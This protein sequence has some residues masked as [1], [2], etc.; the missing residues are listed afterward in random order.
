M[1]KPDHWHRRLLRVR[2]KRPRG[3]TA[4]QRDQIAP[5][6]V[7]HGLPPEAPPRKLRSLGSNS[8]FSLPEYGRRF[9]IK[10]SS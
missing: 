4:E 2:R 10:Y 1:E 7:E 8:I 6:H 9:K 5:S 3:R